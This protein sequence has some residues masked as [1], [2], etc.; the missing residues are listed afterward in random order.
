MKTICKWLF[1]ACIVLPFVNCGGEATEEENPKIVELGD[2]TANVKLLGNPLSVRYKDN[3]DYVY[4]RNIWDM[5]VFEGKVYFGGGNS[6][7]NP[8]ASNAGPADVWAYDPYKKEFAMEYRLSEE[9]LHLIRE[10][11]NQLYIPGHDSRESWDFGNFYRL[12]SGTWKKYRT[13]PGGIHVYDIYKVG[14]R[15]FAAIGKSLYV[16][17]SAMVSEDDG[18]TWEYVRCVDKNGNEEMCKYCSNRVYSFFMLNNRLVVNNYNS[19]VLNSEKGLF[20]YLGQSEA[21]ALY[22]GVP[23][24]ERRLERAVVFK[25]EAVY[26]VG[27]TINDHQYEPQF[28]MHAKDETNATKVEL[29]QGMIPYDLLVRGNYLFVLVSTPTGNNTYFNKVLCTLDLKE[30][31]EIFCFKETS[32]ARSFE[33]LNGSFYFGMGCNTDKLAP[34]TGNILSVDYSL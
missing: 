31:K 16:E 14:N 17:P 20:D 32:F 19:L 23:I 2:V 18:K 1:M 4:A 13:I 27:K 5:Y 11:D 22:M 28:L 3:T 9:Q 7:N 26:I 30:W 29:Q 24:T 34:V 21:N 12:E 33:Y 25:R 6:S 10:F 15:L 8:P